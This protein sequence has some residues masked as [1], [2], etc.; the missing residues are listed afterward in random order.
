MD[1]QTGGY[2]IKKEEL[3]PN[4]WGYAEKEDLVPSWQR[5]K[6]I[7]KFFSIMHHAYVQSVKC[8]R[9]IN[10]IVLLTNAYLFLQSSHNPEKRRVC[11]STTP[12][13]CFDANASISFMFSIPISMIAPQFLQ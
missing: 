6:K 3:M 13:K 8:K 10:Q 7:T 11:V 1:A 9:T 4:C 5:H 12:L 2:E